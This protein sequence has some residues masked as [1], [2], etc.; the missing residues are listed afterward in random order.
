VSETERAKND[1]MRSEG[2][3]QWEEKANHSPI[4]S[5]RTPGLQRHRICRPGQNPLR[6]RQKVRALRRRQRRHD[7][8]LGAQPRPPP[9]L[10]TIGAGNTLQA[11]KSH[12]SV[13]D[14]KFFC[15]CSEDL[16]QVLPTR[17]DLAKRRTP[18]LM[19]RVANPLV[20]SK[21]R[22]ATAAARKLARG[23]KR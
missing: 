9:T 5:R 4:A 22:L 2:N 15:T 16:S 3:D 19:A 7:D 17:P 23:Q 1:Q 13:F 6:Q 10:P 20:S 18:M 21:A 14:F 8:A 12:R 11:N